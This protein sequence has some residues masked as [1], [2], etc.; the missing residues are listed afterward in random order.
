MQMIR[1]SILGAALLLP[2]VALAQ[3]LAVE[4]KSYNDTVAI[5]DKTLYRLGAGVRSKW[6]FNVYV[7][8]AYS[9]GGKCDAS[10][11]VKTD[12]VKYLRLD[13]LRNVSAEKMASTIGGSFGEHMPKNA[14]AEL[15]AQRKTFEAYFKDE[16]T[17]GTTLEF[18]YTPGVGTSLKQNGKDLGPPLAG[19]GFMQVLWDIYFGPETC[20]SSLKEEI[21]KGCSK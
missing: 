11:I 4:G 10:A 21:L 14:S 6:M 9:E 2:A 19:A 5:G 7:M 13:L 1:W 3:P 15:Q 16:C 8:A 18:T 20:C 12:E 17:K